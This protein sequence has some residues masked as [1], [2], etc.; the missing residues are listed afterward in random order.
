MVKKYSS[1]GSFLSVAGWIFF[2]LSIIGGISLSDEF[3]VLGIAA[4]IAG[5]FMGLSLTATGEM[6]RYLSSI[7]YYV[8]QLNSINNYVSQLNIE[9]NNNVQETDKNMD[10]ELPDL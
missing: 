8:S 5:C 10:S 1:L 4:G 7:N 9:K 6:L 2:A 3:G